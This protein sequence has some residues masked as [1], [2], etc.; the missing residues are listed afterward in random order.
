MESI[1]RGL[2][3]C[4]WEKHKSHNSDIKNKK[5]RQVS[6]CAAQGLHLSHLRQA[7]LLCSL[8]FL[9][10]S[11]N[12]LFHYFLCLPE[13]S[14]P[15]KWIFL[16]STSSSLIIVPQPFS[17]FLFFNLLFSI[18]HSHFVLYLVLL[19]FSP[20]LLQSLPGLHGRAPCESTIPL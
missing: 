6:N 8:C 20:V 10:F 15:Q 12:L 2:C 7:F 5:Q 17:F 19:W 13:K 3:L 1:R 18:L 14:T 4:I 11:L 16:L 9:K